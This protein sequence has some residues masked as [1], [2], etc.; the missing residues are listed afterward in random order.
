MLMPVIARIY[1]RFLS[2]TL[3]QSRFKCEIVGF[4]NYKK[5]T[6]DNISSFKHCI[7]YNSTK[8]TEEV[9]LNTGVYVTLLCISHTIRMTA[10]FIGTW[11]VEGGGLAE[12]LCI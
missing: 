4:N 7:S 11:E 9:K 3:F 12:K 8:K 5:Q 6:D 10:N 1:L 2:N